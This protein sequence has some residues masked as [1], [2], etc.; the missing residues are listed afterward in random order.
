[1]EKMRGMVE[2]ERKGVVEQLGGEAEVTWTNEEVKVGEQAYVVVGDLPDREDG[3]GGKKYVWWEIMQCE[4][5]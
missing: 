2:D 3:E 4:S 1:M 5:Y